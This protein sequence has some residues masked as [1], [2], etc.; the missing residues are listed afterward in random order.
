MVSRVFELFSQVDPAGHSSSGGLGIG[1]YLVRRL[2]KLHGGSVEATSHGSNKGSEFIVRLPL[3]SN[4][5]DAEISAAAERGIV[6]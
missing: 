5:A 2:V 3:L 6:G 4:A 1:L